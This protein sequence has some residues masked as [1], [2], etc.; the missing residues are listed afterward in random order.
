MISPTICVRRSTWARTG[1]RWNV[2]E[3]QRESSFSQ[4]SRIPQLCPS[5]HTIPNTHAGQ[6]C[7]EFRG[8]VVTSV[9]LL[10]QR[11]ATKMQSKKMATE[12]IWVGENGS[13]GWG[14]Q[15]LRP[16]RMVALNVWHSRPSVAVRHPAP[17]LADTA[18]KFPHEFTTWRERKQV[19]LHKMNLNTWLCIQGFLQKINI[20]KRKGMNILSNFTGT[21][22][23]RRQTPL[24]YH[25]HQEQTCLSSV[26][27]YI[28]ICML[29][30][31]FFSSFL[32]QR[33]R[34]L[35]ESLCRFTRGE[36]ARSSRYSP[37]SV[38]SLILGY[39]QL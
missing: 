9:A 38:Y 16:A 15:P 28:Y 23:R 27:T 4:E 11:I 34:K 3:K 10:A 14:Q 13:K 36:K 30:C 37:S 2:F 32:S 26:C 7:P 21:F 29:R 12:K 35:Q 1:E 31:R 19:I 17:L 33:R 6:K 5:F 39:V 8:R 18:R 20:E 24:K 22:R 25:P